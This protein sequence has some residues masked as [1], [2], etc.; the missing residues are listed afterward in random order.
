MTNLLQNPSF[1][2]GWHQ[3]NPDS[4]NQTPNRWA[5]TWRDNGDTMYSAGAFPGEDAPAIDAVI[6]APEC[7]H[8]LAAQLPPDEQLGAPHALILDGDV[9]Y[10]IFRVG[11]SATL[12]QNLTVTPGARVRFSAPIQAH[13]HGDGSYGAC[14]VRVC[15]NETC[16]AWAT[17]SG[18]LPDP[19]NPAWV[20]LTIEAEIPE[21]GACIVAI[22]CEG[23]AVAPID[24][25]IDAV[26]LEVIAEPTNG[27]GT[28]REQYEKTSYLMHP[29]ATAQQWRVIAEAA[30][31]TGTTVTASADD[32]GVGDLDARRVYL[33][34]FQEGPRFNVADMV[35]WYADYYPGVTVEEYAVGGSEPDD[36]GDGEPEPPTP[37]TPPDDWTPTNYT[38][39]GTK[40]GLHCVGGYPLDRVQTLAQA[41]VVL[42]TVKLVQSIGDLNIAV[43]R[44]RIA[45]IIDAP[46]LQLEGFDYA[47]NPEAQAE[48]RMAALMPLFAP[49]KARLGWIEIINEQDCQTPAQ[50]VTLARFFSRAMAI[51]EANGYRLALFSFSLGC[52]E[53]DEWE[54]MAD[55]GVFE[56]AAAGGH[57]ISLHEY[58]TA[59]NGPSSIICRYRGLY[60]NIILPMR[61]DIPLFIT[62]YNVDEGR[63]GGDLLAEWAAYDA[64]VAADPYVAGVHVYSLGMAGKSAYPPRVVATLGA[65]VDYAIA[66]RGRV[67][68]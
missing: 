56:L 66:Q 12:S 17:F 4:G 7:V 46:G 39:E 41:G 22:D 35:A 61:L 20:T 47:G 1:E 67:N 48:A 55:T 45:R 11:F 10:K 65:F 9:T 53:Q 21:S 51:A 2:N 54:A 3:T 57:A 64:L 50:A 30:R 14:A 40:L 44:Y 8:K 31:T 59:L 36:G 33:V 37:P 52:P 18:G 32:A 16:S 38:P 34:Q 27:R 68:G 15:V 6:A 29:N 58:E 13:H 28:P 49:Y 62:E 26:A 24:F 60:E 42:P 63:L 43:E 5:L 19:A 25:F 23:R